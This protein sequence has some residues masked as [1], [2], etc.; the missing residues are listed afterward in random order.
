VFVRNSATP[1]GS[2]PPELEIRN[3]AGSVTV[4][5]VE[6]TDSVDVRV[7]ALDN[8]AEQLLD[9]VDIAVDTPARPDAPVR[10]RVIVPQRRLFRSPSFAIRVTTPSGTRA[11]VSA[12]SADVDVRG[13]MGR[14]DL[15]GASGDL[16][17]ESGTDVNART[18]SGDIRIGSTTGRT[19]LASASGDVRLGSATGGTQ[20]RTA[21]GDIEI[22][23]CA[24]DVSLTTAS[25]DL[26]VGTTSGG[27]VQVA[28]VSGGATVGVVPGLRVWLDLSSVSG[29]MDQR[30]DGDDSDGD[31]GPADLSLTMRSVSGHLRVKRAAGAAAA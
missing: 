8:A 2:T 30:L 29:R 20:A 1:A 25:G 12:M 19:T 11:R 23:A 6:G 5:A 3:P 9:D 7:E 21:S 28:T 10:V 31:E 22:D 14:L 24:G 18:A 13:P 27:S 16:A 26:T 17:A 15:S 4:E